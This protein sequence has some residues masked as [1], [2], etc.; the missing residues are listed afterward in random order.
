VT[1]VL[2]IVIVYA[3]E[4]T[5]AEKGCGNLTKLHCLNTKKCMTLKAVYALSVATSRLAEAKR[6]IS[7]LLITIIKLA[8]FGGCYAQTATPVSATFVIQ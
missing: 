8:R 3:K 2:L 7:L 1:L 4:P 6:I 5:G